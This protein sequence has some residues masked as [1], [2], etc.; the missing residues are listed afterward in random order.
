MEPIRETVKFLL[1][2]WESKK[3]SSPPEDP[4]L[5]LAKAFPR[6]EL[7]H[8]Q[9]HY[10][11]SGVMGVK[12]DSSARLYFLNLQKAAIL[13]KLRDN[14]CSVVKD[15]RLSLGEISEKRNR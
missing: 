7:P 9:F 2:E 10:F 11:R 13:K 12:V 15:I 5:L 1:Q 8:I 3:V 6:K 4:E 14:S